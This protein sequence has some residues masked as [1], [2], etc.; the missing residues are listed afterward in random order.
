M[1]EVD[2]LQAKLNSLHKKEELSSEKIE[3][4]LMT[5]AKDLARFAQ[6]RISRIKKA[7]K[8]KAEA[9]EDAEKMIKLMKEHRANIEKETNKIGVNPNDLPPYQDIVSATG[10]LNIWIK[11]ANR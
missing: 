2:K 8:E 5:E 11:R 9:L 10:D 7:L 4:N 6:A 1:K 3:L